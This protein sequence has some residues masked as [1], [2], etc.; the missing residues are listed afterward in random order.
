[1]FLLLCLKG[2]LF[3]K[4]VCLKGFFS[5]HELLCLKG[6]LYIVQYVKATLFERFLVCKS[7]FV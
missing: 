4:F 7:C 5:V 6:F 3:V 2:V 1:V